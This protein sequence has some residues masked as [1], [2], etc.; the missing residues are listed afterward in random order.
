[1]KRKICVVVTARPS[2]ARVKTA[3]QA[4]K[5]HPDLELQLVVAASAV[6]E[7]YGEALKY[8]KK[9]G[10]DVAASVFMVLEGENLVT[11]ARVAFAFPH[12]IF[13]C[14]DWLKIMISWLT[15]AICDRRSGVEKFRMS[16]PSIRILPAC[17][18]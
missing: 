4:I 6:L 5:E 11:S 16:S 1:M 17:G 10:F 14:T 9:D 3:L 7:R 2:Y 12:A 8:I 13:S 15:R 18:S